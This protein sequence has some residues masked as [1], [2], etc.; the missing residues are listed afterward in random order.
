MKTVVDEVV[1]PWWRRTGHDYVG[2]HLRNRLAEFI[3]GASLKTVEARRAEMSCNGPVGE[4]LELPLVIGVISDLSGDSKSPP[5]AEL[6]FQT[7]RTDTFERFMQDCSPSLELTFCLQ[8]TLD[9][10]ST[11]G[12]TFRCLRDFEPEAIATQLESTTSK[13]Q[14]SDAELTFL[15]NEFLHRPKFMALEGAW[16]G[17]HYLVESLGLESRMQI[18]VLS[19]SR[20]Q[21]LK[22]ANSYPGSEF[23]L[24]PLFR[25]IAQAPYSPHS[26]V[27][28]FTLLVADYY[29]DHDPDSIDLMEFLA[30][31]GSYAHAPVLCGAAP[32]LL[33]L[34]SWE[35]FGNL[36]SPESLLEHPRFASW[37]AFRSS[38]DSQYLV[39]TMPRVLARRPYPEQILRG[40]F[41]FGEDV[42]SNGRADQ[43]KMVWFNAAFVLARNAA[44]S[45][46]ATSICTSI[47]GMS[48]GGRIDGLVSFTDAIGAGLNEQFG[49][50]ESRLSY[51]DEQAASSLGLAPLCSIIRTESAVY[52]QVQSAYKAVRYGGR[53]ADE[54][55][56][57]ERSR[58]LVALMFLEGYFAQRI[59]LIAAKLCGNQLLEGFDFQRWLDEYVVPNPGI[60]PAFV[61]K[62]KPLDFATLEIVGDTVELLLRCRLPILDVECRVRVSI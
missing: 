13:L 4:V 60:A 41:G 16:R 56:A 11:I 14:L 62:Q 47:A 3:S 21:I 5:V 9:K 40:R 29:F 52:L 51:A 48:S 7:V 46:A 42:A 59:R 26:H 17:L 39:L 45:F 36:E 44:R 25:Q 61:L 15:V 37:M 28:P 12:L 6:E 24:S 31:I 33:G 55:N 30:R 23:P 1:D 35:E 22:Q 27:D 49:P 18:R 8:A 43:A 57:M 54:L 20:K 38:Y 53:G 32:E 2:G 58:C 34:R 19:L 50:I 10:V